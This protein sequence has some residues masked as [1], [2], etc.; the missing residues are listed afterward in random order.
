MNLDNGAW[1][2]VADGAKALTLV[3]EGDADII[4]LRRVAVENEPHE[5]T[6]AIGTDRPGRTHQSADARRS[7]MEQTDWHDKAEHEFVRGVAE[8]LDVAAQHGRYA[9]LLVVA[10]PRALADLRAAFTPRV[11]ALIVGE[12]AKDLTGHPIPEIEK[13]IGAT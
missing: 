10:A 4:N 3:N 2:L 1:V 5:R 12:L 9:K 6:S 11:Q 13:A 8:W 7:G